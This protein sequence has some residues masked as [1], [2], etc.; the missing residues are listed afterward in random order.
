V[1]FTKSRMDSSRERVRRIEN[2]LNL[3]QVL[4]HL[5]TKVFFESRTK[6]RTST[7]TGRLFTFQI[8]EERVTRRLISAG[9]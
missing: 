8:S 1:L 3:L 2:R 9:Q 7:F 6:T 5:S 4:F